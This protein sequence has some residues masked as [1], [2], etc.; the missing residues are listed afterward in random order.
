MDD[1]LYDVIFGNIAGVRAVDDPD[2]RWG[3][4]AQTTSTSGD[5]EIREVEKNVTAVPVL[6][7]DEEGLAGAARVQQEEPVVVAAVMRSESKF[8]SKPR[9]RLCVPMLADRWLS[10]RRDAHQ[11]AREGL[12]F[13]NML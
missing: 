2:N 4:A 6:L 13:T 8:L 11:E 10:E 5:P 7:E 1:R 3:R 12:H 9:S